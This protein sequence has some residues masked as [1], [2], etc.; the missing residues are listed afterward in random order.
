MKALC[1]LRACVSSGDRQGQATTRSREAEGPEDC[2]L[3]LTGRHTHG[4]STPSFH[5]GLWDDFP[6]AAGYFSNWQ[7]SIELLSSFTLKEENPTAFHRDD[8]QLP[9]VNLKRIF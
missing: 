2:G 3:P 7:L 6:D 1:W 9:N 8:Y 5:P 4:E